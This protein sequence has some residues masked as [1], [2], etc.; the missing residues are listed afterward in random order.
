MS[1][2]A[3]PLEHA[4]PLESLGLQGLSYLAAL[5]EG[6]YLSVGFTAGLVLAGARLEATQLG[7]AIS[8]DPSS[9]P[10][11]CSSIVCTILKRGKGEADGNKIEQRKAIK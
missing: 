2:S 6:A 1:T 8:F 10:E 7:Q 4:L 5:I 11:H 3:E 9:E